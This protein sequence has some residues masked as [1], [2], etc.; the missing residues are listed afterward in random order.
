MVAKCDAVVVMG[1]KSNL[2]VM[3]QASGILKERGIPCEVR[4]ISACRIPIKT[5]ERVRG[6]FNA[7]R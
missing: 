7:S 1:S 4:V 2:K 5:H 3:M 6:D